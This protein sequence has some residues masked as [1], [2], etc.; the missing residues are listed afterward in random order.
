MEGL[1]SAAFQTTHLEDWI[2]VTMQVILSCYY[3]YYHQF[4]AIIQREWLIQ[5]P[6]VYMDEFEF[7]RCLGW[8]MKRE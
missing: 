1:L 7:E 2:L 5:S 6:E 4:S 3:L 8:L